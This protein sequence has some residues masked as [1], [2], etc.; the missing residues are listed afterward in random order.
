MEEISVADS[1]SVVRQINSNT[2][3]E[4]SLQS[5]LDSHSRPFIVIDKHFKVVGANQAFIDRTG[6]SRERV[7]MRPCHE[8]AYNHDRPCTDYGEECPYEKV[9]KT[10]RPC[11][12]VHLVY[13]EQGEMRQVKVTA[14]PLEDKDGEL[15]IGEMVEPDFEQ[16]AQPGNQGRM[17]GKSRVYEKLL[18]QLKLAAVSELPV[19]LEGETG[20]GKEH[21]ARFIH[22][23]SR[24]REKPF[25]TLD[26]TVLTE[27][28]F[29]SEVFGHEKGAFTGSV[30]KKEGLFELANGGTLFLDEIGEMPLSLQSK[31]L[32]LL[33]TGEFRRVGGRK[34]LHSDVRVV[35]AT[36]R[37]LRHEVG[38]GQ[39]REDLYYRIA[40][41]PVQVPPLRDRMEDI[42][43][44]SDA[45]L[46]NLS[47][48]AQ[49]RFKLTAEGLAELERHN[50]P[51]NIRELRNILTVAMT[52]C[53]DGF[54]NEREIRDVMN[55]FAATHMPRSIES[56]PDYGEKS[57]AN[58]VAY[59]DQSLHSLES[60]QIEKLLKQHD[61]N[62]RRVAKA[63]GIS[64]RTMYRKLKLYG[65]N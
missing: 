57:D 42:P 59:D 31:L 19:L 65:L 39:F 6:M 3:L 28:L 20:T 32:R 15:Y 1:T 14:Y 7:L 47:E 16:T 36:N 23:Q 64:E 4:I 33:E 26:C 40:C 37:S 34:M 10:K 27:P 8:V 50:Y 58:P 54:I 12:C 13:N 25:L 61:G 48:S 2:D 60:M 22:Q 24:R 44:I 52:M 21:A 18:K 43:L 35:C 56:E 51:G 29:E 11:S 63:L 46:E 41:L 45:I 9:L 38:T 17:V 5:L 62:R 55:R 53:T 30:G 49:T